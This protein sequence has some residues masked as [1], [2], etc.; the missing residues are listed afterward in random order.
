[1]IKSL[2]VGEFYVNFAEYKV[3]RA[4]YNAP[5]NYTDHDCDIH[6]PHKTETL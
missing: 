2:V 3:T 4:R 6:T 1:M 5:L